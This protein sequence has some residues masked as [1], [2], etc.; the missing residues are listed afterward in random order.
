MNGIHHL[1]GTYRKL[2][3][4]RTSSSIIVYG[5]LLVGMRFD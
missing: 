3:Q 4:R 1:A 5:A 2:E